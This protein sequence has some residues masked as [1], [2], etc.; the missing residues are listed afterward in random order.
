MKPSNAHASAFL[1]VLVSVSAISCAKRAEEPAPVPAVAVAEAPGEAFP[2][3][4]RILIAMDTVDDW[5]SDVRDGFRGTLDALLA[6]RGATAEY[7]VLDTKLDPAT[8]ESIRSRIEAEKPDLV[9]TIV[10]PDGFANKAIAQKLRGGEYRFVSMEAVPVQT[11]TIASWEKPGGNITG[12]GVFLRQNS[13]LR[14]ARRLMPAARRVY[15]SSWSAMKD[16]NDW[17]RGELER[18]CAEE[19][20]ELAEVALHDSVEAQAEYYHRFDERRPEDILLEGISV[21][22]HADG[23]RADVNKILGD[24]YRESLQTV[25]LSY[26]ETSIREGK[27]LGAAVVWKDIGAQLAE[28]AVRVLAG[29]D[30]GSIPWEYPRAFNIMLNSKTLQ[31]MGLQVPPDL[32]EAAYRV[33]TDYEGAFIGEKK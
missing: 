33:Y 26:D 30:P 15:F 16:V 5:S 3:K 7:T 9:C 24:T 27:T 11:G 31:R 20:F 21:F 12:V 29:E 28:K 10:Y 6:A 13:Q 25:S 23:S 4:P 17:F 14:L 22:V 19:G 8:A 1:A 2:A 32:L 18:A